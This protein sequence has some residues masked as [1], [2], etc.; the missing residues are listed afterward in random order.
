MFK[1]NDD[2]LTKVS[3][4]GAH[5]EE[6]KKEKEMKMEKE[7]EGQK[8]LPEEDRGKQGKVEKL[9]L[10]LGYKA[11]KLPLA[12]KTP[13]ATL[14]EEDSDEYETKRA[15][16]EKENVKK[17]IPRADSYSREEKHA[18]QHENSCYL[19]MKKRTHKDD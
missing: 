7:K 17:R 13:E 11:E 8:N 10:G 1:K 15:D 4:F 9:G 3:L 16:S 5:G 2:K 19:E 18:D 6:K 12:N 14:L